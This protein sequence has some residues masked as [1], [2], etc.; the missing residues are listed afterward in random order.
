MFVRQNVRDGEAELIELLVKP[1][2]WSD[3]VLELERPEDVDT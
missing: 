2:G 3:T 1:P